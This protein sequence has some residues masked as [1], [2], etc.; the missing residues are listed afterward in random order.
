MKFISYIFTAVILL[1]SNMNSNSTELPVSDPE[2]QHTAVTQE[3]LENQLEEQTKEVTQPNKNTNT[4]WSK[5]EPV[6]LTSLF[7]C[8]LTVCCIVGVPTLIVCSPV[9]CVVGLIIAIYG[10][11]YEFYNWLRDPNK[12]AL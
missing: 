3:T 10:T 9:I 5:L 12:W 4:L 8:G 2:E 6:I 1:G 7:C 11:T